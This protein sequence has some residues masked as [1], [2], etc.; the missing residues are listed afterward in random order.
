MRKPLEQIII[1]TDPTKQDELIAMYLELQSD[2]A[3]FSTRLI[4]LQKTLTTTDALE[5]RQ[6]FEEMKNVK[7]LIQT[8][9][10]YID[11]VHTKTIL[12]IPN[13]KMTDQDIAVMQAQRQGIR[14]LRNMIETPKGDLLS[15][16]IDDATKMEY[17]V[18]TA[19]RWLRRGAVVL[20]GL[21]TGALVLGVITAAM[22]P[23]VNLIA[24]VLMIP[25]MLS[26]A[27]AFIG[28]RQPVVATT[29]IN[30]GIF[31]LSISTPV[32]T[33]AGV[34]LSFFSG[35]GLIRKLRITNPEREASARDLQTAAMNGY[36]DQLKKKIS[37]LHNVETRSFLKAILDKADRLYN[38]GA[39]SWLSETRSDKTIKARLILREVAKI[40]ENADSSKLTVEE[41][42]D[43]RLGGSNYTFFDLI[44]AQRNAST[45]WKTQSDT[46]KSLSEK[47]VNSSVTSYQLKEVAKAIG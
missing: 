29:Q 1:P 16:L 18:S 32:P 7:Q 25:T 10:S 9:E 17:K 5:Q 14:S 46:V 44:N 30:T 39:S 19:R 26:A 11:V 34:L 41:I 37:R 45:F 38:E 33:T 2:L 4:D 22:T 3:F 13:N 40:L 43:R 35:A 21:I 27:A 23:G 42:N 12:G 36:T 15:M 6:V 24:A 31:P 20:G 47:G 28:L 8:L